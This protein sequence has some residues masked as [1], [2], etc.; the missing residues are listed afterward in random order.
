[1]FD[2]IKE[3]A[4]EVRINKIRD[5]HYADDANNIWLSKRFVNVT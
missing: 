4:T 3:L 2:K 5:T 1:M